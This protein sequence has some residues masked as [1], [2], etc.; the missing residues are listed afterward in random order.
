MSGDLTKAI[1]VLDEAY[2][3]YER[4]ENEIAKAIKEI[5]DILG[6][7][8][9]TADAMDLYDNNTF[10][11]KISKL[12]GVTDIAVNITG[13]ISSAKS[14]KEIGVGIIVD[15][16]TWE[17]SKVSKVGEIIL[18]AS[19][20]GDV[21]D[22]ISGKLNNAFD[23]R[24][25]IQDLVKDYDIDMTLL[26]EKGIL[27]VTMK[28]GT[29]YARPLKGTSASGSYSLFG[30]SGIRDDVLFG[31]NG[32]DYFN[33]RYGDDIFIGGS[34]N[35]TY[36]VD[37]GDIIMDSD[38]KGSVWLYG[39]KLTGGKYDE[40]LGAYT[41]GV[42][43]YKKINGDLHINF[44]KE[45]T[46]DD[47]IIKG[48][49]NKELDIILLEEDEISISISD[50]S[51]K[52]GNTPNESMEFK[53]TL[54]RTLEKDE[55]LR[56]NINGETI[57]FKQGDKEKTYTH[58]WNGDKTKG[59]DI[60]FDVTATISDT[61]E[62]LK[63]KVIKSGKGTIKDDDKDPKD[64]DPEDYDPIIID[65]NKDGITGTTALDGTTYFDLDNNGFKEATGWIDKN[66]GFL[67]YDRNGNNN[68]DNGS[69][70]F[71][72]KTINDTKFK[73][74]DKNSNHGFNTLKEYDLNSDN[75][76]DE[77]DDIFDK[78]KILARSKL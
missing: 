47:L 19:D 57:E 45:P 50:N 39:S 13:D 5:T 21:A 30:G 26:K 69:E 35:D 46:S 67:V 27:K 18:V 33:G 32:N 7:E 28:D 65:L 59:E 3:R 72:N 4:M 77:K 6:A 56:L 40:E 76:I 2:K 78:L 66:D 62:N 49:R 14:W 34:G 24:S 29:V 38:R 37:Y 55:Y 1:M 44:A 22:K 31:G 53:V 16:V 17:I 63:A 11:N 58:K 10:I 41:D 8:F 48:F 12:L 42:H 60:N 71:G 20:L 73:Y 52:E 43:Y 51:S 15:G 61:S 54:N 36:I 68:I 75:I 25:A 70:L 74:T 9:N 64:P 23:I